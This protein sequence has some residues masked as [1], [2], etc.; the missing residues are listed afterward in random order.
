[1]A[2]TAA[3]LRSVMEYF[4]I[5]NRELAKAMSVDPSLVSRWLKGQRRLNAANPAMD[6]LAEYVLSCSRRTDDV[7]WL[8]CQFE[9]D[10]LPTDAPT[11]Y[12][13][14][15]DLIMWLASDGD[16]L[17]RN[18]GNPP[19]AAANICARHPSSGQFFERPYMGV[20][21]IALA[22]GPF[23]KETPERSAIDIFL[24]CD[25]M[26]TIVDEAFSRLLLQTIEN[27]NISVRLVVCVSGN[28]KAMSRLIG[29]Y[30]QPLVSGRL[31]LSVVHGITQAVTN[32]MYIIMPERCAMLLAETPDSAPPVAV[33][34][35]DEAF[36]RE[37]RS[38][39]ERAAHY[40]Q[41]ALHV[42]GD[43]FSRNILEILY[44]EYATPG[45]LDVVKD[46]LNPMFMGTGA[47]GR[48]LKSLGLEGTEYEW[49][50]AEFARFKSG[51][52][53]I[54]RGG[55]VFREILSLSRLNQIAGNGYCR[56]PGLY[57]MKKGFVNLDTGGCVA[58]LEGYI[59]YLETVPG[60]HV[61]VLNDLSALNAGSCWHI[62]RN[63][64]VAVNCWS[65]KEPQM[66]HTDQ[67]LLVAEFQ[68]LFDALW[69]QGK[70]CVGS[71]AGV[72]AILHDVLKRLRE[73]CGAAI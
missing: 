5:G 65:G 27:R 9:R 2:N 32:Q 36:L 61:L 41:N 19:G 1:M 73:R 56:M 44:M 31:Q 11:V 14:K 46:S 63:T 26:K 4:D 66:I 42:Y 43:D 23:F 30:M 18:I 52:D 50:S 54:L 12:R 49:R 24:A 34:V 60:F 29:V 3:K 38:S 37:I 8:K 47:Y 6:A 57:F 16:I 45:G 35:S 68:S 67:I 10:G 71:R 51:M 20:L 15:Q 28:T 21:D 7:E 40:A 25:E 58:I 70:G 64:S 48:A 69:V 33:V 13:I 62:K 55:A 72:V 53:D 59:R 39:F 17:R 22:M